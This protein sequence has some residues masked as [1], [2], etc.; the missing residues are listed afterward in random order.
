MSKTGRKL[1][2]VILWAGIGILVGLQMGGMDEAPKREVPVYG[3]VQERETFVPEPASDELKPGVGSSPPQSERNS[4]SLPK[5]PKFE[6]L[7]R[8]I[9]LPDVSKP[10]ADILADKTAGLLQQMSNQSIR[11]VVSLFGS[12]TD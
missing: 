4:D 7:P 9:L 11:W 8:D 3:Q 12:I 5:E 6:P 10:P 1:A 2:A